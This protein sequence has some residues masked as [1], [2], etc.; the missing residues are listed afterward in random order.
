MSLTT[1]SNQTFSTL[2]SSSFTAAGRLGHV[3]TMVV[4]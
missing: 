3:I 2:L 4:D 1:S